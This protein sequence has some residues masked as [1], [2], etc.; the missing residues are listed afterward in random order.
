MTDIQVLSIRKYEQQIKYH[1]V[2]NLNK[3]ETR[4]RVY[5]L[6]AALIIFSFSSVDRPF[7]N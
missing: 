1:E 6:R 5:R 7:I 4:E 2:Y 3:Y